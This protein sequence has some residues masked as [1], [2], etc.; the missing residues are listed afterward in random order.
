MKTIEYNEAEYIIDEY[1]RTAS[2][3]KYKSTNYQFDVP[4]EIEYGSEKF[5][6]TSIS[7]F[8]CK[9]KCCINFSSDSPIKK[10]FK[11]SLDWRNV[12]KI[13]VP[14]TIEEIEDGFCINRSDIEFGIINVKNKEEN[15][16]FAANAFAIKS[17]PMLDYYDILLTPCK[18][19]NYQE[20]SCFINDFEDDSN[21][22]S[23][24][25]N[26]FEGTSVCCLKIQISFFWV[27]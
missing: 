17:D 11:S 14:S 27:P 7:N 18:K 9:K 16:L 6:V 5:K 1:E 2:L 20:V 25:D 4:N 26:V 15:V 23:I 21:L 10:I 13:T 24:G 19:V 22:Y 3:V 12:K 8:E